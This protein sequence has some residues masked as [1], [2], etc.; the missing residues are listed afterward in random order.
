M[1]CVFFC[2]ELRLLPCKYR[3]WLTLQ[4][5]NRYTVHLDVPREW[6]MVAVAAFRSRHELVALG[7]ASKFFAMVGLVLA[8]DVL[9][10]TCAYRVIACFL[11]CT[12]KGYQLS[13]NGW[14]CDASTIICIHLDVPLERTTVVYYVHSIYREMLRTSG[15]VM[16]RQVDCTSGRIARMNNGCK[17]RQA[18]RFLP[19]RSSVV[20]QQIHLTLDEPC[21]RAIGVSG[22]GQ[23]TSLLAMLGSERPQQ[24][25]FTYGHTV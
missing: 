9:L 7:N 23:C 25:Y 17:R 20:P 8:Q 5:H 14:L 24:S 6:T 11:L 10:F 16:P 3:Q 13:A 18:A 2:V 19:M 21:A 1:Y 4:C 12:G 15:D 22:E